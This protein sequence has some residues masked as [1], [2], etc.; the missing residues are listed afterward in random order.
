MNDIFYM[1]AEI[2][3]QRLKELLEKG[4]YTQA[5]FVKEYNKKYGTKCTQKDVSRWTNVGKRKTENNKNGEKITAVIGFP[6]YQNMI[7]LADFFNVDVGFLS[8]E[9]DYDNFTIEKIS[10]YIGLSQEAIVK[11]KQATGYSTALS[12][13]RLCDQEVKS[14]LNNFITSS[15]FFDLIREFNE[16]NSIYTAPN[17]IDRSWDELSKQYSDIVIAEALEAIGSHYDG[18]E[19]LPSAEVLDAMIKINMLL[20]NNYIEKETKK[21]NIDTF[22][23]RLSKTFSNLVDKLYP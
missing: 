1:R 19:D 16:L 22:K 17:N 13:I 20:D 9:T 10:D 4:N 2:W 3:N 8:G 12:T 5:S 23:Y 15:Y 18:D 11:I 21:L 7:L 6:S 14:V